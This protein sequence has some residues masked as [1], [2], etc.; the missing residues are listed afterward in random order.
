MAAGRYERSLEPTFRDSISPGSTVYA[1]GA[2]VGYMALLMA[3]LAGPT[4][5][6]V[7]F[8]ANEEIADALERNISRNRADE[9]I[10]ERRAVAAKPGTADFVQFDFSFVGRIAEATD[11]H[12]DGRVVEV[13]VV[14]VDHLV[15]QEGLPP[16]DFVQCTIT[17]NIMGVLEGMEGVIAKRRPPMILVVEIAERMAVLRHMAARGYRHREVRAGLKL[18]RHGASYVMFTPDCR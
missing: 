3:K 11:R 16:P 15:E 6:I 2:H 18:H 8:E 9:V 10:V 13:P 12:A 17:G 1:I 7:A 4:G 5:R 14:S